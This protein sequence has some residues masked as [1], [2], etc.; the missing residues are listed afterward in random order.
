VDEQG[1]IFSVADRW[2]GVYGCGMG[3]VWRVR[4]GRRMAWRTGRVVVGGAAVAGRVGELGGSA[5]GG[6]VLRW[7]VLCVA[8]VVAAPTR[9]G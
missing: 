3:G 1:G 8:C 7:G 5:Q 6:P 2:V 4:W 9:G